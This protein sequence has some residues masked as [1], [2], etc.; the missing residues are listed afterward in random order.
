MH[1]PYSLQLTGWVQYGL[2]EQ[3][4]G[5]LYD[6]KPFATAVNGHQ[7]GCDT[8]LLLEVHQVFLGSKKSMNND[9]GSLTLK[10]T[11]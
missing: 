10:H 7:E 6:I 8:V 1:S 3:Y 9:R 2:N 11:F 4:V 5:S